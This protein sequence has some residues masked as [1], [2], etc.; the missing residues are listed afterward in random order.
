LRPRLLVPSKAHGRGVVIGKFYPPHHGHGYLIESALARV[1][2]LTVIVCGRPD[3][4]PGPGLRAGWIRE[5]H[6]A[7]EVMV[8]DDHYDPDDSRLWAELTIRWLGSPPD[9]AFTSEE[10]GPRW[11]ALMGSEHVAVDPA[12]ARF[13]I[14]GTAI[15]ADPLANWEFL[16]PCVRA[17][18]ARRVV[19]V[20]AESTGTTTLARALA[21]HYDT[22]WVPEYGRE[23]SEQMMSRVGTYEWSSEDFVHIAAEQARRED[24]AAHRANRILV[25]DTD[26]FATTI[27]HE[28]YMRFRSPAIEAIAAVRR[29]DLYI[30]TGTDIP[31]VQD[32]F[33]D[34]ES[35]REWM[36]NR[37]VGELQQ[38]GKPYVV[39]SGSHD[40]R[41]RDAVA[42]IDRLPTTSQ[43]VC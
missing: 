26:A 24:E 23:Y 9:V 12:R 28:R 30:V 3:E 11:A 42:A 22:V 34:G 6:P 32:G 4:R 18:Y 20:G 27:W 39:V 14:S 21:E 35:I 8:V 2:H 37:F 43:P 36:H 29:A 13:Q 5:M 40:H 33:R 19:V 31:F 16:E 41:M 25:C 17:F 15:R 7:V 10:Y 1:E 38:M